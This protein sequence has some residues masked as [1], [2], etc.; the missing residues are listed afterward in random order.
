MTDLEAALQ[1]W[2]E[3]SA[4][5][6]EVAGLESALRDARERARLVARMRFEQQLV[7]ALSLRRASAAQDA[8]GT[9]RRP[10]PRPRVGRRGGART[11]HAI[12]LVVWIGAVA[13]LLV[14]AVLLQRGDAPEPQRIG[15]I[16]EASGATA[17][18]GS[19]PRRL[20][21]GDPVLAGETLTT[22]A[23]GGA[24]ILCADGT[25]LVLE[26]DS[27]VRMES[28]A[29]GLLIGLEHGELQAAVTRRTAG[30]PLR[31]RT[32]HAEATILGTRFTLSASPA[33]T[34]LAVEQGLVRFVRLADGAGLDV[35]AGQSAT[36]APGEPFVLVDPRTPLPPA[37]PL[38]PAP[39]LQPPPPPV[40]PPAATRRW[41]ETFG[42]PAAMRGFTVR[43]DDHRVDIANGLRLLMTPRPGVPPKLW[44]D[45]NGVVSTESLRPPFTV[46]ATIQPIGR[47]PDALATMALLPLDASMPA[48]RVDFRDGRYDLLT[49]GSGATDPEWLERVQRSPAWPEGPEIWEVRVEPDG[50]VR[51]SVDG[52]LRLQTSLRTLASGYRLGLGGMA[53]GSQAVPMTV[54]VSEASLEQR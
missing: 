51:F 39:P 42:S 45:L 41:H 31:V 2:R 10:R 47:P 14:G 34:A 27:E 30:A 5:E 54:I 18:P 19:R 6:D 9:R 3:G 22:A 11:P 8:S 44:T 1:R 17:G 53:R 35:G 29:D 23:G 33:R 52:T 21:S 36:V 50:S 38:P 4:S 7:E 49:Q 16:A 15:T 25:A 26:A 13:A 46:S 24:R 32:A 12:P 48:I 40:P 43:S 37:Q 28:R 20:G